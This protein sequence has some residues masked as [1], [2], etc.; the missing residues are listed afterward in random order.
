MQ[1][2]SGQREKRLAK[3][4]ALGRVRVDQRRD[5]FGMGLPGD[6][7]LTFGDQ[8]PDPVAEQ[9]NSQNGPVFLPDHLDQAA[10]A[11][12]LALAVAVEAVLI[13]Y[14]RVGAELGDRGRLR[15]PDGGDLGVAVRDRPA[16]RSATAMP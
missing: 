5:V 2:F 1:W 11:D 13:G 16:M 14:D 6:G 9:M 10:R 3:G 12:D 15:Q 4:L 7:E 8:L